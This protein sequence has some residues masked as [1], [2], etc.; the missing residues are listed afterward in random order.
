MISNNFSNHAYRPLISIILPVFNAG[1]YLRPCMDTLLNQTLREIEIICILD[2]PTDGSDKIIEEYALKDNRVIIIRNEQNL[3]IGESRNVGLRIARGEYIGFSD[4]DDTH[5]LDM[6][7]NLYSATE[8]GKKN[9]VFSG[10]LVESILNQEFPNYLNDISK[11]IYSLPLFHQIFYSLMPRE[12]RKYRMHITPNLYRRGFIA[13]QHLSFVD[14][15]SCFAEDKLFLLSAL[16][17]IQH[18]EEIALIPKKLYLYRLHENNAHLSNWY[19]DRD[20]VFSHLN[21]ISDIVNKNT[22]IDKSICMRILPVLQTSL[23]YS[24]FRHDCR[25]IGFFSI[26]K[27][28]QSQLNSNETLRKNVKSTSIRIKGISIPKRFFLLWLKSI[29]RS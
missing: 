23:L 1:I 5:E 18:D 19:Y 27:T 21:Y 10:I 4:H 9:I 14:T 16:S 29:C 22:W 17:S 2:C 15:K 28:Y 12:G 7:E 24:T 3:S 26:L 8:K 11:K 25:Q 20:H 13:E 6:Y